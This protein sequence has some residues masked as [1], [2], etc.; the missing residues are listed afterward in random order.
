MAAAIV[1]ATPACAVFSGAGASVP[2]MKMYFATV[3][4]SG[5]VATFYPTTTGAAGGTPL[6]SQILHTSTTAWINTASAIGVADTG[7]KSISSDLS[8]ITFNVTVGTTVV[9]GNLSIAFAPDGTSVTCLV[10]GV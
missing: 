2:N 3:T 8:T 4:T 6:F 5:G 1:N 9:L 10:Y 7:G